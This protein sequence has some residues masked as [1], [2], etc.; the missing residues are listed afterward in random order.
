MNFRV[1]WL[2]AAVVVLVGAHA[3]GAWRSD[4][5][6]AVRE[7]R[8]AASSFAGGMDRVGAC[9]AARLAVRD[10]LEAPHRWA[11]SCAT[12]GQDWIG[13]TSTE[14]GA[15][16]HVMGVVQALQPSGRT[17]RLAFAVTIDEGAGGAYRSTVHD[18]EA[19]D[20]PAR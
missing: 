6:L 13:K 18:L 15:A 9:R 1:A 7:G 14:H 4:A 8:A 17:A 3:G 2:L 20:G 5:P 19:I 10:L 11:G 16:W 12:G